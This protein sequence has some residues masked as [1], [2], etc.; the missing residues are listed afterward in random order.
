MNKTFLFFFWVI[1][2]LLIAQTDTM[3]VEMANGSTQA[4][5]VTAIN[6]ITFS[7]TPTSVK[8]LEQMHNIL[9][10]FTLRQNY[11]NPFNPTTTIE[12]EIPHAG[13]VDVSIFDIQGRKVRE[14]EK[15]AHNAGSYKV[16]WDS[17][18]DV[19]RIVASG[20]YF[21]RVQFNGSQLVNKLLLLK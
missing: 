16:V 12:Y 21:Y 9:R 1:P 3:F 20:T 7:Q 13:N 11:P 4:Y 14:L 15:T 10:S 6:Q 5:A 17:R 19:G 2:K 8:E 18:N